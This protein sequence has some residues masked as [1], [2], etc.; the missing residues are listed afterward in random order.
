MSGKEWTHAAEGRVRGCGQRGV[1]AGTAV[2]FK[3]ELN[4]F[5]GV[6]VPVSA[7]ARPGKILKLLP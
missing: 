4:G 2:N 1:G 3:K 7:R 6:T 5:D